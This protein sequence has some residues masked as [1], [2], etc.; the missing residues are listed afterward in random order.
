VTVYGEKYQKS[1]HLKTP[2]VMVLRKIAKEMEVTLK[3]QLS[4]SKYC[5]K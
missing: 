2:L 5:K 4:Y 3:K 1:A